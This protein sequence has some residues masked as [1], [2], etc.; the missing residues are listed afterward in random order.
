MDLSNLIYT[1]K[2]DFQK[3]FK[4]QNDQGLNKYT[5]KFLWSLIYYAFYMSTR[6][7]EEMDN[8]II[9]ES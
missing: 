5:L 8:M 3:W 6:M 9:Y 1:T 4:I 2:E 7:S